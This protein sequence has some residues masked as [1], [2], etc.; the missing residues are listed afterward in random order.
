MTMGADLEPKVCRESSPAMSPGV[1]RDA[2]A[3][4]PSAPTNATK[5]S[6]KTEPVKKKNFRRSTQSSYFASKKITLCSP[7][8]QLPQILP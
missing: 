1:G 4:S 8:W 5:E 7:K 3:N 6:A 2:L